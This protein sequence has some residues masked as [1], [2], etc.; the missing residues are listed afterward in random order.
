MTLAGRNEQQGLTGATRAAGTADAVYVGLGVVRDVVVDDV[1][2]AVDVETTSRNV[3][4]HQNVDLAVLE[5]ADG[6]L[7]L[8]LHDV[9][10]DRGGG[11]APGAQLLGELFG[12]L[13]GAHEHDH[14]L[15]LFDLEDSS[16]RFELAL[17]RHL[18]VALRDVR[19]RRRL[20]LD[21]DLHR[22]VQVLLGD[23]ADR[24]R[25]RGREQRDLLVLGS[26]GEDAL[27]VLLEPH[28][29]HLVGLVEHEVLEPGQVERAL[30]EVVD[31]AARGADDDLRTL[32][33][34]G[35]LDP[36]GLA[37]VDGQNVQTRNVG[38]VLAER[39]GHLQRE[40]AGR[41]QHQGLRRPTRDVETGQDRHC[42]RS[43]LT[44][45]GLREADDVVARHQRRDGGRLD[46]RRALVSDVAQGL[47]DPLVYSEIGKSDVVIRCRR[48]LTCVDGRGRTRLVRRHGGILIRF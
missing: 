37:A 36:V 27:H 22:I 5:L 6:A 1:R 34:A 23:L 24:G 4:G 13:L 19:C 16:E 14:G 17:M 12:G 39:L 7:T 44:R 10:V 18:H 42:E 29:E 21:G 47:Q 43:G 20:G 31:D 35:Q 33:Q 46:G 30:L 11:E 25:H 40:L 41:C 2:D 26:V 38:G 28:L 3:G 8:C 32:A 45:S 15:E 48:R 9:A